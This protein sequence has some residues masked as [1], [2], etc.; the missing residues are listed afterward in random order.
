MKTWNRTPS[1]RICTLCT[2]EHIINLYLFFCAN[3]KFCMQEAQWQCNSCKHILLFLQHTLK[4][5]IRTYCKRILKSCL[6]S[7]PIN[8]QC[9]FFLLLKTE[10][11]DHLKKWVE[12]KVIYN[13]TSNISRLIQLH[14]SPEIHY[15]V[16]CQPFM[17]KKPKPT[18][19]NQQKKPTT[20]NKNKRTHPTISKK[21][22]CSQ[23]RS[24]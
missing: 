4:R 15:R 1:L 22:N 19:P 11:P 14:F 3:P 9:I 5:A 24:T 6:V 12:E 7:R 13:R 2:T 21:Q 18:K 17:E 23:S 10:K 16:L 8:T 20:R